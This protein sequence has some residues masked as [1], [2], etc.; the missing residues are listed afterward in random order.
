M[1][2][3]KKQIRAL[4]RLVSFVIE[5]EKEDFEK[6]V[7]KYP[8]LIMDDH[9]YTQ[10]KLLEATSNSHDDP[11]HPLNKH[12]EGQYYNKMSEQT[13]IHEIKIETTMM[14]PSHLAFSVNGDCIA[15][16]TVEDPETGKVIPMDEVVKIL[17]MQ[18]EMENNQ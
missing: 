9:I 15:E 5:T 16:C 2:L 10:A 13:K 8:N 11:D 7:E 17:N 3:N 12:D 14:G 18:I 4:K 6:Y 1:E